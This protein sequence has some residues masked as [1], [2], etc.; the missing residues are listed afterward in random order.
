MSKS[1]APEQAA[2][3]SQPLC[4]VSQPSIVT[5][6]RETQRLRDCGNG[7]KL[8]SRRMKAPKKAR[9]NLRLECRKRVWDDLVAFRWYCT[10]IQTELISELSSSNYHHCR[11]ATGHGRSFWCLIFQ[12]CPFLF[13]PTPFPLEKRRLSSTAK[14]CL[15]PW[16]KVGPRLQN[17]KAKVTEGWK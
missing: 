2:Q 3:L 5:Y 10:K 9:H 4:S 12:P 7:L 15:F 8:G 6:N 11:A 14:C 13:S 17:I 16:R 1:W